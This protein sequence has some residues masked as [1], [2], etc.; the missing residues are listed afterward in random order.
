MNTPVRPDYPPFSLGRLPTLQGPLIQLDHSCAIV[1]MNQIF[2]ISLGS[3]KAARRQAV[4]GFQLWRPTV[5]TCLNIP[6]ESS[7]V[8]GLQCQSEALLTGAKCMFCPLSFGDVTRD[9]GKTGYFAG[10]VPNGRNAQ[11]YINFLPC[12]C[13]SNGLKVL[14]ALS[15]SQ[16]RQNPVLLIPLFW[17][18]ENGNRLSNHFLLVIS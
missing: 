17:W 6:F 8:S 11:R 5:H 14:D 2:E 1:G 10:R 7:Q 18:D 9:F 3:A 12:F 16:P 13:D 4:Q 15:R